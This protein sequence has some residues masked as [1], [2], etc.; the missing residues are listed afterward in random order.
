MME[1]PLDLRM[2]LKSVDQWV[3][4]LVEMKDDWLADGLV[5]TSVDKKVV[6][7]VGWKDGLLADRL[8]VQRAVK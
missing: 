2:V 4:E 5:G 8:A 3:D 6:S 7:L 1:S